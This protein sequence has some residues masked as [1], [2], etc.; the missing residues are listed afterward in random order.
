MKPKL[1]PFRDGEFLLTINNKTIRVFEF[2]FENCVA[3][4]WHILEH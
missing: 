3:V 4:L 1:I 2:E